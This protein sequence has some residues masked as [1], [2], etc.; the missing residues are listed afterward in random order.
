MPFRQSRPFDFLIVVVVVCINNCTGLAH[1]IVSD[2]PVIAEVLTSS[3]SQMTKKKKRNNKSKGVLPK[4]KPQ[5]V[6]Q[7]QPH[8]HIDFRCALPFFF[9]LS[10]SP[11][12][13]NSSKIKRR[14]RIKRCSTD[15]SKVNRPQ[16]VLTTTA[17]DLEEKTRALVES[18]KN[19][20]RRRKT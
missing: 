3:T 19:K 13:N 2:L 17:L 4:G 8:F 16:K 6:I 20:R 12:N 9:S 18:K 5:I 11:H 1:T 10:I 7:G 14:V 15:V